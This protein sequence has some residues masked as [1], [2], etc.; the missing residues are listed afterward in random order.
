MILS[1]LEILEEKIKLWIKSRPKMK[2][3]DL[4]I[5]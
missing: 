4:R 3:A 1:L 2:I 5:N